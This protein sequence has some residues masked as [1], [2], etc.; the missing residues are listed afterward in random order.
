MRL[1]Q[2]YALNRTGCVE[3]AFAALLLFSVLIASHFI[4]SDVERPAPTR[5][6]ADQS[7]LPC[8]GQLPIP[9]EE[10]ISA[11]PQSS[12]AGQEDNVYA[13]AWDLLRLLK[14]QYTAE[15]VWEYCWMNA[16]FFVNGTVPL[17][18]DVRFVG[19][20]SNVTVA[21][22]VIW[23]LE[24]GI[25]SG[26]DVFQASLT[27]PALIRPRLHDMLNGTYFLVFVPRDAGK[28][29]VNVTMRWPACRGYVFCAVEDT[30][31]P[32]LEVFSGSLDVSNSN[33]RDVGAK[34]DVEHARWILATRRQNEV[35]K[36]LNFSRPTSSL[37]QNNRKR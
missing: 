3:L 32:V 34:G 18:S 30:S 23:R 16:A 28:F 36:W 8:P 25:G 7:G 31:Q 20:Q 27:G 22:P 29:A 26:G 10:T 24:T 15:Q 12:I 6:P 37:L 17:A 11:P 14:T 33:I 13:S 5:A 2:T 1:F 35:R 21:N 9:G 4:A 19:F